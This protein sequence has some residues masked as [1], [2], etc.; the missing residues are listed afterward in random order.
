M[1]ST[2]TSAALV[3]TIACA[4]LT[5]SLARLV[6]VCRAQLAAPFDLISEGPHMCTVQAIERGEN[7]YDRRS[8][9]DLPF[10]MTP[11]TPLYHALVAALPQ[12]A[13]NPF[14]T[15][16]VVAAFFMLLAAA[17]VLAVAPPGHRA[18][19]IGAIA[20]FFLIRP[21]TGNTAYLRSDAMA[22]CASAWAVVL[23]ARI[24]SRRGALA[25]GVLCAVAVAAKQSFLAAGVACA[26]TLLVRAPRRL[27]AFVLGG[28]AVGAALAAAATAAWGRDFWLA[29]TIPATDYPR[30]FESFFFHWHLMFVQPIFVL[31]VATALVVTVTG[32]ATRRRALALPFLAYALVAWAVQTW[33]LTGVGA[34]NHNLIEPV[35]ATVL[36]LVVA[37]GARG[38]PLRLDAARALVVAALAA[39]V[40]LELR[41]ADPAS[42][43]HTTPAKTARYVAARTAVNDALRARGLEHGR[44]LNL[45]NSQVVHDYVGTFA[46]ND[47]WMYVTVLW[48]S[49]PE[50]VERLLDAIGREEF[51]AVFVAPGV[52]S[53]QYD[54]GDQPWSRIIHAVFA[55]Y[56]L[57]IH[58]TEVNVLT[59]RAR[60]RS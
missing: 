53:A 45:K 49:R 23:A 9:L 31:L 5:V 38:E 39:C 50:T 42:Y 6:P 36:W 55:H 35:L 15:G 60:R 1:P 10:F 46:V 22:L 17:S 34:E 32:V 51:D 27:G 18:V 37:E 56:T 4:L 44:M 29:V 52:L 12:R 19:A 20:V 54:V 11:Y 58:G 43:S 2:R 41:G 26:I 25:T 14:F 30:D 21:V 59:R 16:R 48:N 33:V 24:R 7:I 13:G 28:A 40:T 3:W 47:L 57:A 8:F